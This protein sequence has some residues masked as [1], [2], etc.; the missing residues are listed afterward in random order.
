M[1]NSDAAP[2]FTDQYGM[3]TLVL[4]G[5]GAL[6]AYQAGVY[7]ELFNANLQ[8]DWIS[9]ASIGAI[10]GALIAGNPV[11]RRLERLTEF[12]NLVSSGL[13]PFSDLFSDPFSAL[14]FG[15]PAGPHAPRKAFNELSS[16]WSALAGLPGFFK[17]RF[18]PP[19]LQPDGSP[20]AMS[21]YE[22]DP[23]RQ[24]LTKLVDFT[25]LNSG[26]MRFSAGAVN[27][28]TGNSKYFDTA[29]GK[30]TPDHILASCA[31]PPSFPP[32][33]IDGEAYWDGG[34]VSNT[35]LQ[36][37][38]DSHPAER[39]CI[40]QVDLFCA[41]GLLPDN[42]SSATERRKEILYSSRRRYNSDRVADLA[43]TRK[44]LRDLLD[45]FP[46]QGADD[47]AARELAELTR[48]T[49]VDIVQLVYGQARFE[50]K[51]KES[52]FSRASVLEHWK[53]GRR[54]AR[55]MRAH[56]EWLKTSG[57]DGGVRQYELVRA[58]A[59]G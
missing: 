50:L 5:G 47:A 46:P 34:L 14:G 58:A 7:E 10:N 39:L 9:G 37:V 3:R 29:T 53:C 8:P 40:F 25:L 18:P 57:L 49:P 17:P 11:E 31:L 55:D 15:V 2:P 45:R 19:M 20:G 6:G 42:L 33:T 56:P 24:T 43:N 26:K 38:L 59:A 22:L 48:V 1:A 16:M 21:L 36:H 4:H 30:I 32:V 51:S 12:W 13:G 27:V 52:E 44:K 35:P 28:R 41:R 54:D 23:L